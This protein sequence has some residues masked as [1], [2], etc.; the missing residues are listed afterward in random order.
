MQ[1]RALILNTSHNDL[2]QILALKELGYFVIATGNQPGLI[3]ENYVN[4]YV[5]ADYSNKDKILEIANDLKIDSICACCNDFGVITAAYV[6]EKMGLPG[7][8]S[9]ENALILHQKDLFKQF[10]KK[11][12]IQ[13]PQTESFSKKEDAINWLNNS[14]FP[15]IIKPT[16][17]TGGKGISRA[18]TY[19]DAV[20]GINIAFQKSRINRIVIEPFIKGTQHGCCTFILN[21]K[22]VAYCTN[23][24]YSFVNPFLVE[25]DTYPA[26]NFESIKSFLLNEIERM[27]SIMKLKD[28]IF[29]IQYLLKDNQPYIIEAMRRV[30]GNLYMIPAERHTG[31][32]WDYWEA[33]THCGLDCSVFPAS[34]KE[35][36]FYAYK[37][38]MGNKNGRIKKINIPETF[39]QYIFDKYFL[40]NPDKPVENYLFEQLGFLFFI[41]D[42]KKEMKYVLFDRYNDIYV[43]YY[44]E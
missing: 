5:Q 24:E 44:N 39:K 33:R 23:N 31:I 3:G 25:I 6:A 28:G 27:C 20:E 12:G 10:T 4:K 38:I 42:T 2:R 11:Y 1:K 17:L 9:Y 22:V 15:I 34:S 19:N 26:D 14:S 40:W 32:N 13:A 43:E 37:T 7:H 8:D 29:H 36:K 41:F 18:D 16:D 21:G 35:D 30:L